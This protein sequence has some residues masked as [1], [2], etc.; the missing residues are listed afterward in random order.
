VKPEMPIPVVGRVFLGLFGLVLIGR[1][2]PWRS[3]GSACTPVLG[4]SEGLGV[5]GIG[6]ERVHH[7]S[8]IPS[9]EPGHSRAHRPARGSG[10][11]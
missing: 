7:R 8:S 3:S 4:E 6:V 5:E 2:L 1:P 10:D 11:H 9:L